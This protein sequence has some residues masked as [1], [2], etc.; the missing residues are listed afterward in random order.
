MKQKNHMPTKKKKEM[1]TK[2]VRHSKLAPEE[3]PE[4]KPNGRPREWTEGLIE[5]KRKALEK[6]IENP[7]EFFFT[8]YLV[9]E[10]LDAKQIE[11]FCT[12]SEE[13]RQTHAR[14]LAMQ[15]KRIVEG[16]M[17]RKFDAT[18]AKFLLANK[19]GWREK[20]E[21]SGDAANPLAVIMDRIAASARDPLDYDE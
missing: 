4:K 14:A 2:F 13:F 17:L 3:K 19:A 16:A 9:Q 1:K 10:G 18:F 11:R 7:R 20:Q 12:Y 15:E 8:S 21:I 6:W 5:Q